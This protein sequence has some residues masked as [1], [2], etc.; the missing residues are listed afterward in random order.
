MRRSTII[1]V[2]ATV[3]LL[4]A[5]IAALTL[6]PDSGPEPDPIETQ[7]PQPDAFA[8]LVNVS[9]ED[10]R[11]IY[12]YPLDGVEY[13]LHY[14]AENEEI[15]LDAADRIFP[16]NADVMDSIFTRATIL[17]TLTKVTD[18]ADDTQLTMF[19]FDEP[20]MSY[21]V[22]RIDGTLI[23]VEVGAIQAI[24]QGRYARLQ[25]SREI[26]LLSG[27]QSSMLTL[28]LE[29]VYDLTFIPIFDYPE[30]DIVLDAI[31]SV[32]L[33]TDNDIFDLQKRTE[34]EML[35]VTLGSSS[36]KLLQP[37]EAEGND[38]MI[39][40]LILEHIIYIIPSSIE[41]VRPDDLSIYGL[42]TPA[43]L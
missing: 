2:V 40:T 28:Q 39:R 30:E 6:W 9:R 37:I 16:G 19:G 23:E 42:D 15:E 14:D 3:V 13:S 1:A 22:E 21:C 29:D 32:L 25:N 10:V 34:E 35:E 7:T 41:A 43:R 11:S 8:E 17:V 18:E 33:E 20:V 12:F 38:H 31:E 4:S 5:G 26:L 24:G 36:F 27:F